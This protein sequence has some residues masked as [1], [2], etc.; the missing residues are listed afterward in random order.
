MGQPDLKQL[1]LK[2]HFELSYGA[3][4]LMLENVTICRSDLVRV[5]FHLTEQAWLGS[6]P[7]SLWIMDRAKFFVRTQPQPT[8]RVES[9]SAA[10]ASEP[11]TQE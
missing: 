3:K 1:Y 5:A 9:G 6:Q 10:S 7:T 8:S 11:R 2:K 4:V